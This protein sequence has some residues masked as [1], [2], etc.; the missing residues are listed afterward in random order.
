MLYDDYAE[1]T[2]EIIERKINFLNK[3]IKENKRIKNQ[4]FSSFKNTG[5]LN[6]IT[7]MNS[8]QYTICQIEEEIKYLTKLLSIYG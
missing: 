1:L 7:A 5:N 6:C 4:M 2:K 8:S 3:R